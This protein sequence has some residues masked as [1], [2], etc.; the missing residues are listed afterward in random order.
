MSYF[1]QFSKRCYLDYLTIVVIITMFNMHIRKSEDNFLKSI[2]SFHNMVQR[3][4]L[5]LS[6]MAP[7]IT[8]LAP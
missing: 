8:K 5:R 2:P 6:G 1:L 3:I 4:E 7:I